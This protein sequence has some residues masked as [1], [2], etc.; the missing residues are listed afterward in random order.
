MGYTI[1]GYDENRVGEDQWISI[2]GWPALLN[3]AKAYSKPEFG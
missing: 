3:M 1:V 2:D